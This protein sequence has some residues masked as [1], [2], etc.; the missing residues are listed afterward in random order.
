MH[1]AESFIILP[2][3]FLIFLSCEEVIGIECS[4]KFYDVQ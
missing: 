1:G 2:F 4:I 3:Y